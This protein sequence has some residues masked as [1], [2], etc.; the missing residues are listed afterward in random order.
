[1][2]EAEGRRRAG[3]SRGTG[4]TA[5]TAIVGVLLLAIAATMA[6]GMVQCHR[7]FLRCRRLVE[8]RERAMAALSERDDIIRGFFDNA[9]IFF[10]VIELTDDNI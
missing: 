6:V 7:S 10:S 4:G 8:E 5:W 3:T 2:C 9:D 1:M